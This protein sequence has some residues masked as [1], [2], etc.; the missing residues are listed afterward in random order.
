MISEDTVHLSPGDNQDKLL[1]SIEND[2]QEIRSD[3]EGDLNGFEDRAI[4]LNI[5]CKAENEEATDKPAKNSSDSEYVEAWVQASA[6]AIGE[7]QQKNDSGSEDGAE[8]N[9]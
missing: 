5:I 8:I 1:T 2:K 4:A 7:H 6:E 9:R 3:Y